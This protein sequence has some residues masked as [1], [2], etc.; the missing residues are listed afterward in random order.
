[1]TKPFIEAA[2]ARVD[3]LANKI[4]SLMPHHRYLVQ[5]LVAEFYGDVEEE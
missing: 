5:E 1:V 4:E 2:Q 3:E